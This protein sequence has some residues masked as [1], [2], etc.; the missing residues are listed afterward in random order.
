MLK[1]GRGY[2]GG[3]WGVVVRSLFKPIFKP[4]K[5]LLSF[6][7][8]TLSD[9]IIKMLRKENFK[10][11]NLLTK[12]ICRYEINV[13][14]LQWENSVSDSEAVVRSSTYKNVKKNYFQVFNNF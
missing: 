7:L 2:V 1:R 8:I 9:I 14:P 5:A 4:Y 12:I 11:L 13:V 10:I 3:W 6:F